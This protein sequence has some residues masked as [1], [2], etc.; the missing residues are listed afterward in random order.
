MYFNRGPNANELNDIYVAP[1]SRQGEVLA[2]AVPVTE[3]NDPI[4]T[5]AGAHVRADGREIFFQS[6]RAGTLGLSDLY[7]STRRNPHEPWSP[8]RNLGAP[9]N[10]AL[11]D[12]HAYLSRDATILI[13]SS[14]RPG[15]LGERDLWMSTRTVNG[16]EAP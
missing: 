8:P 10:S 7:V 4:A 2:A 5:D 6:D 15:G 11:R 1:V 16:K 3:L 14:D 12:A 13:F 9:M